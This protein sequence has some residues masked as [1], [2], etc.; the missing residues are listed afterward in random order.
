MNVTH[1]R[2]LWIHLPGHFLD[3][4]LLFPSRVDNQLWSGDSHVDPSNSLSESLELGANRD[5]LIS[6]EKASEGC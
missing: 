6:V 1:Q 3:N 5:I 4:A 2:C